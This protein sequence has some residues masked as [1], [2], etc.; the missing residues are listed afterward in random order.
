MP[1]MHLETTA[2]LPENA[3]IPDILEALCGAISRQST[4]DPSNVRAYHSF[5]SVWHMGQGAPPSFVHLTV[6][7]HTGRD[8]EWRSQLADALMA[9]LNARLSASLE[10]HEVS[11]TIDVREMERVCYRRIG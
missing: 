3:D 1:H 6:F 7:V 2:D 11:V 8:M 9:V 10:A 5:R 4:V